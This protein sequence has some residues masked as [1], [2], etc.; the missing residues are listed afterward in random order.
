MFYNT[1]NRAKHRFYEKN[2]RYYCCKLRKK[3]RN[4]KYFSET[5]RA[6]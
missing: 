1:E 6:Y 2:S 4:T 3:K 5:T